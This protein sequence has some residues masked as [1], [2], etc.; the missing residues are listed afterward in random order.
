LKLFGKKVFGIQ[1]DDQQATQP[2]GML[3]F[4]PSK[5]LSNIRPAHKWE[6]MKHKNNFY[7]LKKLINFYKK[8]S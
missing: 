7:K 6:K 3:Q 4:L 2:Q 5:P 8:N 1:P